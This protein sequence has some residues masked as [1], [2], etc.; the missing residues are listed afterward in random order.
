MD[1]SE[2]RDSFR[3]LIES[4]RCV[5]MASVHDPLAGRAAEDLGFE[6]GTIT[7][8][9]A[10]LAV[11]GVP[12]HMLLTMTELAQQ[13]LRVNRA[14]VLPL[15]IDADDGYGNALNVMRTVE[16]LETA[17]AAAITIEDTLLPRPYGPSDEGRLRPIED[18]IGRMRAAITARQDKRLVIV[19][20]TPAITFTSLDDAITRCVAYEKVGVDA[21]FL[22]GAESRQHIEAVRAAIGVPMILGGNGYDDASYDLAYLASQGVRLS[23]QGHQPIRAAI[24]AVYGAL[25]ALQ[26]GENPRALKGVASAELVARLTRE[27]DYKRWTQEFLGSSKT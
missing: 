6:V 10:A 19:G 2:R 12:D 8:S 7:G 26:A 13:V 9:S 1:W 3:A 5:R 15:M 27:S 25:Q 23:S 11:L 20:R 18:G 4:D 24:Q 14:C 22:G 21:I 16:E 17:G